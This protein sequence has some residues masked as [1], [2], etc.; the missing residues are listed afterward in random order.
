LPTRELGC[1]KFRVIQSRNDVAMAGQVIRK[2][3]VPT[4][5]AAAAR[6]ERE[7]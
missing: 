7:G 5:A 3:C 2:E 6:N 1:D 4:P